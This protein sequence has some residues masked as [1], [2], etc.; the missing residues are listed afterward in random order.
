[1]GAQAGVF[2]R[3][4]RMSRSRLRDWNPPK[5]SPTDDQ[6]T[7]AMVA[8]SVESREAILSS[9]LDLLGVGSNP[10]TSTTVQSLTIEAIAKRAGVSKSTI[11]RWWDSKAAVVIDAFVVEY[12][13]RTIVRTDLPFKEALIDHLSAVVRQYAGPDGSIVAQLI[14]ESQFAPETLAELHRRFWDAR[15]DAVVALVQRGIAEGAIASEADPAL[16]AT[17]LYAPV[18]QRLLFKDGPLDVAFAQDIV[19]L[20]LSGIAR[21]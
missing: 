11:Y 9:T 7:A 14:A 19:K 17:L 21:S 3:D 4:R 2:E 1:M 20:A 18:Y 16:I 15:R 5:W 8:R 13:P 6:E 10:G 12:L